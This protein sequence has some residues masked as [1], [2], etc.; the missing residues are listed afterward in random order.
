MLTNVWSR[1]GAYPVVMQELA[2]ATIDGPSGGPRSCDRAI[3]PSRSTIPTA[4]GPPCGPSRRGVGTK[5]AVTTS[6]SGASETTTVQLG[7]LTVAL[8]AVTLANGE[9][10]VARAS[11]ANL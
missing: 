10:H 2:D 6:N 4:R 7:Q 8:D 5:F 1:R 11:L 9:S 3:V